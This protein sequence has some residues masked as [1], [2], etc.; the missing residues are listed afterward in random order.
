M[1]NKNL[2]RRKIKKRWVFLYTFLFIVALFLGGAW[3]AYGQLSGIFLD[4][5]FSAGDSNEDGFDENDVYTGTKYILLLG[6]DTREGE[7]FG[8]TDTIILLCADTTKNQIA[9][10]SIPRDTWVE[11]PHHGWDKINAS[12]FYGGADLC[13]ETVS[14]LLD[15][16][17]DDYILVDYEGFVNIIDALGGVTIDVKDRMYHEDEEAYIIDLD[18]GLQV[19]EGEEAL[20][21][22][23]YRSYAMGDIARTQNQQDFLIALSNEL[24]NTGTVFKIPKLLPSL[25]DAMT[26]TLSLN[27]LIQLANTARKMADSDAK[28]I[29]K[30]LDGYFWDYNEISYW[31]VDENKAKNTVANLWVDEET[32]SF[33][34]GEGSLDKE[35]TEVKKEVVEENSA[36]KKEN[37]VKKE[38]SSVK[39]TVYS[40][41]TSKNNDVTTTSNENYSNRYDNN[42]EYEQP[43][44]HHY[45][46]LEEENNC[47]P[48]TGETSLTE[49]EI[50]DG[51]EDVIDRGGVIP[52]A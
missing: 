19:L 25:S 21:F 33:V 32:S 36:S 38:E 22:V 15:V 51:I 27:E 37:V 43:T 42:I 2:G 18:P 41:N 35:K 3:W 10:L 6:A 34:L 13:V 40:N 17:I 24:V 47:E 7:D 4:E 45:I 50:S 20:Q 52:G 9:L 14:N 8:R 39:S 44:A 12:T 31:R 11:I 30:T 46:N 28:I 23:R 29:T 5:V 1:R 49:K 26:T 16:S 48:I